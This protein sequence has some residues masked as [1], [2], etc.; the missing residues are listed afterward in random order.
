MN[1]YKNAK[2]KIKIMCIYCNFETQYDYKH[3]YDY[4]TK[5]KCPNCVNQH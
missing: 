2:S 3:I 1:E 4:K 5:I